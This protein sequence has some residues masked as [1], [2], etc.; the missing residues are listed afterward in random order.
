MVKRNNK[1]IVFIWYIIGGI[2][3]ITII[4]TILSCMGILDVAIDLWT[5]FGLSGLL[6]LSAL[7]QISA[8]IS[9]NK[10]T[11]MVA[12]KE[13]QAEL[14]ELFEKVKKSMI[15]AGID[16]WDETYPSVNDI[17]KDIDKKEAYIVRIG[18]NIVATYTVNSEADR[19]YKFGSWEDVEGK[20]VVIH[21]LCVAPEY[22]SEGIGE[23]VMN[24]IEA[25]QKKKGT[26]SIRLDA[27][28]KNPAALKLYEK[29]NYK[30]VGDAYWRK[31]KFY[32]MEKKL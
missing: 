19:A 24:H 15:Q 25:E 18:K 32:L 31:G 5:G 28:T 2:S 12:E 29:L 20:Y 11:Y 16:Q 30:I 27:F 13:S 8:Y 1:G 6:F 4:L 3:L 22:Q 17:S 23:K 26:T 9:E 21:R 10:V 7:C 14:V